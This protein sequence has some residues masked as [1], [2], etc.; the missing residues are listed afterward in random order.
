MPRRMH[1][2]LPLTLATMLACTPKFTEDSGASDASDGADGAA[3]GADGAGDGADG[4]S[5]DYPTLLFNELMSSNAATIADE[6]GAFPD[7]VE[8]YNPGSA[9]VSLDGWTITDDLTESDKHPFEAGLVVPAGGYLLLWADDDE[10]DGA[11]HLGF[12]LAAEGEELG[13]YDPDGAPADEVEF[14]A[15]GT[16]VSAAREP[17]GSANWVATDGPTPGAS[18]G[19]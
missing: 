14:G 15:L 19:G 8:L 13:L 17:D 12:N 10:P 18:N 9:D 1:P 2:L 11:E 5:S 7:W 6:S 3:D 4:G 16:D